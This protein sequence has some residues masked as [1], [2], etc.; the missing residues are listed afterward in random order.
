MQLRIGQPF[1][2][3]PHFVLSLI[4]F[5]PAIQKQVTC[6]AQPRQILERFGETGRTVSDIARW[7]GYES[8]RDRCCHFC[9]RLSL[10]VCRGGRSNNLCSNRH[11]NYKSNH[12]HTHASTTDVSTADDPDP[13]KPVHFR[14]L[15]IQHYVYAE[16]A[17]SENIRQHSRVRWFGRRDNVSGWFDML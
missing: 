6:S 13:D 17:P 16:S 1:K 3:R 10:R 11:P 7:G 4:Y 9:P 2:P 14:Q 12:R 8:F 15:A 5:G